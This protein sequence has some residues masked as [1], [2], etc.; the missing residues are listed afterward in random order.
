[1][2]SSCACVSTIARTR[3]LL[4]LRY[5][6]SGMTRS[7]PSISS[8]GNMRPAST[9]RMSSPCSMASMFFPISPTP[10]S[11]MIR[12]AL[13]TEQRHLIGGLL[14]RRGLRGGRLACEQLRERREVGLERG[15]QRWLM[16]RRRGVVDGEDHQAIVRT[17]LPVDARDGLG[18]EE[19]VH[20]V[21]AERDDHAWLK[22]AEMPA[23]PHVVSRDL[24][25]K[26]I[27]VLR[28]TVAHDVGD[29]HLGTIETDPRE[30]L[31]EQLSRRADERAAL[32]VLVV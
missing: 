10:P 26:W 24:V 7:M 8:S 20:G 11:G 29:E 23:Q 27:A 19:L 25:R 31:V 14:L 28:R 6:M 32:H 2:W 21:A 4:R 15:A 18:R 30:E 12:S 9:T 5:V 16:Q 1:M 13:V 17:R 3:D 22:D